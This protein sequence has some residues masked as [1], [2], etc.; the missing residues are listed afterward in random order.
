[1]A[2]QYPI[3]APQG[4]VL[5]HLNITAATVVKAAP[6]RLWTVTVTTAGSTAGTASDVATTGGVAAANLIA[7]LPNTVGVYSLAWPCA[8]GIVIT[9]G[10]GQVLSVAYA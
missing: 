10:T 5:S 6:G 3:V 1:M 9:P 7:E 8:T 4:G 2:E